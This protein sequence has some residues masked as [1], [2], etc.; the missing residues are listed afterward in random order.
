LADYIVNMHDQTRIKLHFNIYRCPKSLHSAPKRSIKTAGF[1]L[2][3]LMIV[4]AIIGTLAAIAIPSL[5]SYRT[6]AKIALAIS[7]IKILE[8]EIKLYETANMDLPD[9]LSEVTLGNMSDPWGSS[10][11]YLKIAEDDEDD[12][13]KKKKG[14]KEK[15][16]KEAKPR[17]DQYKVQVN[18]DF[19]LYSM[20]KDGKSKS[21]F[22][23][24]ASLDD[25]V[26]ANNGN[27]IGLASEF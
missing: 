18:L 17:E 27:F 14:K 9:D 20:G 10:Y 11:Q 2:L 7:E 5:I 3:E 6:K 25:I 1:T 19:D 22:T 4:V 8:Q 23:D 21:R 12:E 26:R 15:G 16:K 24:K 13:G